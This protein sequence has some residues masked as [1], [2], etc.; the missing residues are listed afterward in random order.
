M[1]GGVLAKEKPPV[2]QKTVAAV[3]NTLRIKEAI[4][5]A[6]PMTLA[7]RISSTGA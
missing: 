5:R 6:L 7:R 1:L 2:V 3:G 4:R